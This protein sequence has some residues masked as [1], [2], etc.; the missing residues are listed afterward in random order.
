MKG[1]SWHSTPLLFQTLCIGVGPLFRTVHAIRV[2]PM[3]ILISKTAGRFVSAHQL[4][5]SADIA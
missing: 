1:D 2:L 4:D 5:A 3:R